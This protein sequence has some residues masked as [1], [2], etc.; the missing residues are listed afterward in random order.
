MAR[1]RLANALRRRIRA[2][3][4]H[5]K[6]FMGNSDLLQRLLQ[7]QQ[8][9]LHVPFLVETGND[10]ADLGR[11]RFGVGK[12]RRIPMGGGSLA[13]SLWHGLPGFLGGWTGPAA[14]STLRHGTPA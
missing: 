3:I 6:D 12:V 10:H 8:E 1:P 7:L 9:G 4:I 13:T 11:R 14:W 5:E 2:G